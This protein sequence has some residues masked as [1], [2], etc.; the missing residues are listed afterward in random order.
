L[1]A[2]RGVAKGRVGSW[3]PPHVPS[4]HQ[5]PDCS[6]ET[7]THTHT[8]THHT[9]HLFFIVGMCTYV[10][11]C[12]CMCVRGGRKSKTSMTSGQNMGQTKER[13]WVFCGFSLL[14]LTDNSLADVLLGVG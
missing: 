12:V 2:G 11:L 9:T 13:V 6:G 7:D 10:S 8:H 5:L 14:F 4:P 3:F 1:F